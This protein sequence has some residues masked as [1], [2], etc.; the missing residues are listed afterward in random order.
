[1]EHRI[2]QVLS[3][4][5]CVQSLS[6]NESGLG[7][8]SSYTSDAD[9]DLSLLSSSLTDLVDDNILGLYLTEVL[10][11]DSLI[12]DKQ[13]GLP[14][15]N[16]ETPQL[17]TGM[18]DDGLVDII[19]EIFAEDSSQEGISNNESMEVVELMEVVDNFIQPQPQSQPSSKTP[20]CAP[21]S[22]PVNTHAVSAVIK[23]N[24]QEQAQPGN[25][26]CANVLPGGALYTVTPQF[27]CDQCDF[28]SSSQ[29][30]FK[31]HIGRVHKVHTASA[32]SGNPK[33]CRDWRERGKIKKQKAEEELKVLKEQN[34]ALQAK[35]ALLRNLV[36]QR[37]REAVI[38]GV[39]MELI[40][41]FK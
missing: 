36:E 27:Q 31:V 20:G 35:E 23:S 4:L 14:D 18:Q 12:Q 17:D 24:S 21:T 30:G 2:N 16:G 41:L 11:D 40:N 33:R 32:M 1:M 38:M 26:N 39:S 7:L 3:F 15:N 28:S 22:I 19:R 13:L 34:I 5:C 10:V 8:Q 25:F 37:R 6:G 9:P 29:Q